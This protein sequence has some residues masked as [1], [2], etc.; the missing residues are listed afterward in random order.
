MAT[1][2]LSRTERNAQTKARN[3][4]RKQLFASDSYKSGKLTRCQIR[5]NTH[6]S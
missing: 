3:Q 4:R 6:L 5:K 2:K 1:Q